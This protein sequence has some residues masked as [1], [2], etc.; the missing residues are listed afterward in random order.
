MKNIYRFVTTIVLIL[1]SLGQPLHAATIANG[2]FEIGPDPGTSFVILYPGDTSI[3]G[4]LVVGSNSIDYN[5]ELQWMASD[6]NRSL[7]LSGSP[8]PGAIEQTFSTVVNETYKVLFDLAG[9]PD[10]DPR[11][12]SPAIK[13]MRATVSSASQT[14]SNDF[15]FDATGRTFD[16][17]GWV[18]QSF[19]F[20]AADSATTLRFASLT[21]GAFGPTLDNVRISTVPEPS[22]ALLVGIIAVGFGLVR[23]RKSVNNRLGRVDRG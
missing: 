7:D 10:N 5:G 13:Q 9:N 20:T 11:W 15:T 6:G 19:I 16:D 2:S 1:F 18:T 14:I 12:P 21:D 3:Q 22:S 17:M 8:G 23:Q 4:W